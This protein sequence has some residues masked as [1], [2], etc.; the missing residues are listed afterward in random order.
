[1]DAFDKKC[2][3]L[4]ADPDRK[5]NMGQIRAFGEPRVGPLAWQGQVVRP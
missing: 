1:M 5:E 3:E 2:A 4:R